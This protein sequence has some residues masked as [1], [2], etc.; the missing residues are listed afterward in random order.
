[1]AILSENYAWRNVKHYNF[2]ITKLFK[3][4][5]KIENSG[6][7]NNKWDEQVVHI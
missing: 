6:K 7:S 3:Q 1:M 5:M 4:A 2:K